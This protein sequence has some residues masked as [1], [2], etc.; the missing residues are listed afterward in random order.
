MCD[1]IACVA[2]EVYLCLA[3][4]MQATANTRP[5]GGTRNHISK[6]SRT[7]ELNT[8]PAVGT[9]DPSECQR[10]LA[11]NVALQYAYVVP[12]FTSINVPY[13]SLSSE[14]QASR[15]VCRDATV[16]SYPSVRLRALVSEVE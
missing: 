12:H 5:H 3:C 14:R 6:V 1:V 2:Y 11:S 10:P 9:P 16:P 13:V 4:V 8:A 7:T 15:T